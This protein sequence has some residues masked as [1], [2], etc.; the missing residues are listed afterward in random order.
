M[1]RRE[2]ERK[3]EKEERRT[4]ISESKIRQ[5]KKRE[6]VSPKKRHCEGERCVNNAEQSANKSRHSI[7]P[8]KLLGGLDPYWGQARSAQQSAISAFVFRAV[9]VGVLV[10]FMT[11]CILAQ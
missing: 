8:R 7:D 6:K 1:R 10:M 3:E 11:A 9:D 2:E 4:K 5:T